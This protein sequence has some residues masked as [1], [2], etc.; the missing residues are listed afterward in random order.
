MK[1]QMINNQNNNNKKV[2]LQLKL[3]INISNKVF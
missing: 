2:L 3:W 1:S